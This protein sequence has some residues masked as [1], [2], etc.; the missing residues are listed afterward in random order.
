M[1]EKMSQLTDK[2]IIDLLDE[3]WT[4]PEGAIFRDYGFDILEDR[5]GED[6]SDSVYVILWNKHRA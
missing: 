4:K 1:Y 5:G 6:Y 3:Y 2:E